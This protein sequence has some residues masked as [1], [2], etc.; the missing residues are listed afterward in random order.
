MAAIHQHYPQCRFFEKKNR[1]KRSSVNPISGRVKSERFEILP[2]VFFKPQAK[3]DLSLW[4]VLNLIDP[5]FRQELEKQDGLHQ[6]TFP[7]MQLFRKTT[8]VYD[9]Q[10]NL[11]QVGG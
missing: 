3:V 7:R 8:E 5:G 11:F 9:R 1:G 10:L 4:V 2:L 6:Y